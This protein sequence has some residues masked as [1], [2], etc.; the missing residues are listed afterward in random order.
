[1]NINERDLYF[2]FNITNQKLIQ[3]TQQQQANAPGFGLSLT[4]NNNLAPSH[5]SNANPFGN[6]SNGQSGGN[7]GSLAAFP[8]NFNYQNPFGDAAEATAS[9]SL[10]T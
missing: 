5:P 10:R 6:V 1:M 4:G 7:N 3:Q 2:K 8:T 9:S